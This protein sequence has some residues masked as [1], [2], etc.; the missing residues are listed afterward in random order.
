MALCYHPFDFNTKVILTM[1][2][3]DLDITGAVAR[4]L[5]EAEGLTQAGF[6]EPLGV[7]Q[8]VSSRYESGDNPIPHAVRILLVATYVCGLSLDTRTAESVTAL[9]RLGE[10]Q[11]NAKVAKAAARQARRN[12]DDAGKNIGEAHAALAHV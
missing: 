8:S 10:I 2:L 4:Q 6:W 12:L 11:A 7:Q 3:T 9:T 1:Q 5:R